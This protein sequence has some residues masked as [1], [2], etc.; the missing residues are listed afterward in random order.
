MD[1]DSDKLSLGYAFEF[2][3]LVSNCEEEGILFCF[4]DL[5]FVLIL[6]INFKYS[7]I[8]VES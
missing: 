2:L 8:K 6:F 1:G 5:V 3:T 4:D 7:M